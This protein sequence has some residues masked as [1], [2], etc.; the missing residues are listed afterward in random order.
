MGKK[1][2]QDSGEKKRRTGG[3]PF[4]FLSVTF[5]NTDAETVK[6]HILYLV[7]ASLITKVL[8]LCLTTPVFHSFVDLFD[9]GYYLDNAVLLTQGQIP[10]VNFELPYPILLFV[11]IVLALI[12]ALVFQNGMAFVYTFSALMVLCDLVI[13]LCV[14]LTGLRIWNE[15]RAFFSGLVYAAAFSCSY[16]VLTKYDAF[17][18]ALMMLGILFTV[19]GMTMKGYLSAIL[20]FFAKVFPVLAVPFFV[21]FNAKK[22]SLKEEIISAAKVVVP[23]SVVLFLP[24]FLLNPQTIRIYVPVRSELGYYSNTATFMIY[25]WIHDVIH[26]G[27]SLDILSLAM[28]GIMGAGILAL[29]YAVYRIPGRD[30]VLLIKVLL[31]TTV[32]VVVCARVR[33]PQYIVWFTP[34]ICLLAADDLKKVAAF[35]ALQALA[36]IEFPLM[37]GAFYTAT[38]YTGPVLSAGWI[39][40]L[41]LFT[42][43]YL[44]LA[45]CLWLVVD[46]VQLYRDLRSVKA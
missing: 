37:F 33:S 3:Q 12:P 28:Y 35:F 20:G 14:Y 5:D 24:I 43:E 27:I 29:L 17:P 31:I 4:E 19:Y 23:V 39:L 36:Y 41:M 26:V 34:L 44:A 15:K 13:V 40:T 25:S 42:L 32:L 8:V 6:R 7:A 18:T 10:Y 9:I 16:F 22:T 46:P 11:P 1:S 2:R 38:A 30:P 21:L 45:L